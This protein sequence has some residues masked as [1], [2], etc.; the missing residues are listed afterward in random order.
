NIGRNPNDRKKMAIVNHGGKHAL[1]RYR[2]LNAF[3]T[4]AALVECRLATGRTHQIRVH[5]TAQ[6]HPLVGDKTYGHAPRRDRLRHFPQAA[7]DALV[8]FQ[9]QALHAFLIGFAHPVTA[10]RLTFESTIPSDIN[11]LMTILESA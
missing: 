6:G 8:Q 7:G 11:E 3:G 1:T 5:M 9:R 2:V 4:A 10:E